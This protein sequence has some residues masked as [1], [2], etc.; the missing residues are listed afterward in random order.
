MNDQTEAPSPAAASS[1]GKPGRKP[2]LPIIDKIAT[3]KAQLAEAEAEARE[4]EK[5]R[6]SIV[7][8]IVIQA[9]TD[10]SDLKAAIVKLLRDKVKGARDK[11]LIAELLI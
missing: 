6:D 4:Q 5:E 2:A 7:G 3:L 1:R 9:M 8:R 11:T 10:D